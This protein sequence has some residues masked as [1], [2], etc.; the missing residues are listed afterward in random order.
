MIATIDHGMMTEDMIAMMITGIVEVLC[1][2]MTEG[3]TMIVS[4]QEDMTETTEVLQGMIAVT[5]MMIVDHHHQDVTMT[6][7]DLHQEIMI[8]DLL[9]NHKEKDLDISQIEYQINKYK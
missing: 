4:S 3:E 2:M 7:E 1:V 8:G 6:T 5:T 9:M